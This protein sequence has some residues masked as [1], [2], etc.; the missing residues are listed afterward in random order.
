MRE[1]LG[2]TGG[3]LAIVLSAIWALPAA[4]FMVFGVLLFL[5]G[6]GDEASVDA[7]GFAEF[8]GGSMAVVGLIVLAGAVAG[9]L[10]GVRVRRGRNGARVG[11][12]LLF[13]PFALVSGSF[14]A[15]AFADDTG[16]EPGAVVMFG[17][18]TAICLAVIVCAIAGRAD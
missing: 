18:N 12:V 17:V 13:I 11:L 9:V 1:G 8:F 6:R 7:E 14:L 3:A 4:G 10:L 5:S 15:S 2:R 16:V